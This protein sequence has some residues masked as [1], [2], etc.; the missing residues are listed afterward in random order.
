MSLA[1]Q[2]A[3]QFREVVLNG[4][5]VATNFRAQLTNINWEQATTKVDTLN[6]IATLTFHIDYYIA[7]LIQV[8]QGG[9]LD[10]KDKYSFDAPPITSQKDWEDRLQKLWNNAETF[11]YLIENLNDEE[12]MEAFVEEKYGNNYINIQAMIEH[13]Y[14]HLGQIVLIKKLTETNSK[15]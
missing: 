14:Y 2:I 8:F 12:L 4:T 15:S 6:T 10:I 11:A 5:W 3:K 1:P 13:C 9:S 7:G